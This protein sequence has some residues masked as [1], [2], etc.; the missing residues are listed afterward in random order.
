MENLKERFINSF[1]PEKIG[2][3]KI[4]PLID[5]VGFSVSKLCDSKY[6]KTRNNKIY[7]SLVKIYLE[8]S[9]DNTNNIKPIH[10]SISLDLFEDDQYKLDHKYIRNQIS[11]PIDYYTTDEYYFND[12]LNKFYRKQIEIEPDHILN[13]IY[14][15][16]IKPTKFILGFIIRT[17]IFINILIKCI[18][19]LLSNFYN[20]LLWF[21]SGK[22]FSFD[23][24]KRIFIELK[25]KEEIKTKEDPKHGKTIKIFDY[26]AS[27]HSIFSYCLIHLTIFA[28]LFSLNYKPD[29]I[30]IILN[31]N[32][33]TLM[34]GICSLVIYENF[35][36]KIFRYLIKIFTEIAFNF[37]NRSF[38]I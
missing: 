31:Y 6:I 16:H 33:L 28:I 22:S 7:K 21:I 8:P 9:K 30:R 12:S 23:I 29:F 19:A 27:M 36:P 20:C 26:Q 3:E 14:Q 13:E 34:Y 1:A 18:F 32:L 5:A 37:D 35:L 25:N 10:T 17:N 38:K 2:F 24:Y 15:N 11:K 4:T